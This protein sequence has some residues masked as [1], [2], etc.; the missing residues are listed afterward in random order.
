MGAEVF[1]KVYENIG[2]T[3]TDNEIKLANKLIFNK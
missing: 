2:H 1:E 3:I